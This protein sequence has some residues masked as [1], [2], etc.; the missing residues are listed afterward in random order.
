MSSESPVQYRLVCTPTRLEVRIHCSGHSCSRR[1]GHT[2][3]RCQT[4][5]F[6]D[7]NIGGFQIDVQLRGRR[8]RV[9]CAAEKKRS[10]PQLDRTFVDPEQIIGDIVGDVVVGADGIADVDAMQP[11]LLNRHQAGGGEFPILAVDKG[12]SGQHAVGVDQGRT[13]EKL[14]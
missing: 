3:S 11:R 8:L 14:L 10:R 2:C 7:R 6:R 4:R 12:M 1:E 13:L 5:H 9:H